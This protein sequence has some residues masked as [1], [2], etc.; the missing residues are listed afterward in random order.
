MISLW[1]PKWACGDCPDMLVIESKNDELDKYIGNHVHLYVQGNFWSKKYNFDERYGD[2]E[3]KLICMG[4]FKKSIRMKIYEA[5]S[6]IEAFN[7]Q[8]AFFD[9]E[10]CTPIK[11]TAPDRKI[12]QLFL[13]A[14]VR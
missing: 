10:V 6:I 3:Y 7:A 9:A 12:I 2:N 11:T 5:D 4:R 13:D 14:E 1:H 8:G